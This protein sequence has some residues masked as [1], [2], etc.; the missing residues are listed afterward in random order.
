MVLP[1]TQTR[2]NTIIASERAVEEASADIQSIH[3]PPTA[4]P[5]KLPIKPRS[6]LIATAAHLPKPI[7]P[8]YI[9][10]PS[11]PSEPD[12]VESKFRQPS[13]CLGV[14]H[15]PEG[16]EPRDAF[17]CCRCVA[18][19]TLSRGSFHL[20]EVVQLSRY[21][22]ICP[23]S[24]LHETC[25]R[26]N[27]AHERTSAP[28]GSPGHE[29]EENEKKVKASVAPQNASH[30]A[31]PRTPETQ[32]NAVEIASGEQSQRRLAPA[33][34]DR[35]PS[36]HQDG[37]RYCQGHGDPSQRLGRKKQP[38]AE[39]STYTGVSDCHSPLHSSSSSIFNGRACFSAP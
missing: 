20:F 2:R 11:E 34:P 28:S 29:R 3:L 17:R 4:L 10:R 16:G 7:N 15:E 23:N 1:S 35:E 36:E 21:S 25:L 32:D 27:R 12:V 19:L 24:R 5:P 22:F 14:C 6:I 31:Q 13:R 39:R 37:T 26:R 38:T 30:N 9:S 33:D 8:P 18:W